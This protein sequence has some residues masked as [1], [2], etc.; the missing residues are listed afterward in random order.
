MADGFVVTIDHDPFAPTAPPTST[1][2]DAAAQLMLEVSRA[3][4]MLIDQHGI[5]QYVSDAARDM[6]GWDRSALIGEHTDELVK[7]QDAFVLADLFEAAS[8]EIGSCHPVRLQMR[9]RS[10]AWIDVDATCGGRHN[11]D[12]TDGFVL[13]LVAAD[14][15]AVHQQVIE[16]LVAEAPLDVVFATIANAIN[17]PW[18]SLWMS[19]HS[20][21]EDN[22]FSKVETT[23]G[24][25]TFRRAL[26]AAC[27]GDDYALWDPSPNDEDRTY[28]VRDFSDG[29]AL[30][31]KHAGLS[32]ARMVP[33]VTGTRDAVTIVVWY[34][35]TFELDEPAFGARVTELSQLIALAVQRDADR[36]RIDFA[37]THDPLT[38]LSN[39][40]AFF[41]ALGE[42]GTKRGTAVVQ[43]DVDNFKAIN[44]W[45]G[46]AGGDQLLRQV[47]ERLAEAVR[48]GDL[49]ARL[50]GDEFAILCHDVRNDAGATIAERVLES[51]EQTFLLR[52]ERVELEASVGIALAEPGRTS[53]QLLEASARAVQEVKES[54]PGTFR[55]A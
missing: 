45:H 15:P 39:R 49:V 40:P 21:E 17:A 26:E 37:N 52:G 5:V 23:A 1:L 22:R 16:N 41:A 19:I 10:D 20:S 33:C 30:A 46:Q 29:I 9:G 25:E 35:N 18:N 34:E 28:D 48:P 31:A 44:E 50:G 32:A 27:E 54:A 47:A 2:S 6:F 12:D 14:A 8:A 43:V 3:V 4:T 11:F 13:T 53:D 42:F 38:G 24:R 55:I 7:P 51:L 36:A